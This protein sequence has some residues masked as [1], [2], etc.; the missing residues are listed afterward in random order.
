MTETDNWIIDELFEL[1]RKVRVLEEKQRKQEDKELTW[2][3]NQFRYKQ[4][5]SDESKALEIIE[6]RLGTKRTSL[7]AK[8]VPCQH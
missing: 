3:L 4:K 2:A 6:K 8:S 5:T 7:R 1:K